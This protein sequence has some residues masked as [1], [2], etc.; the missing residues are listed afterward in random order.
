[1]V[2]ELE[3]GEEGRWEAFVRNRAEHA[4]YLRAGWR[5]VLEETYGH[6][7]RYLVAEEGGDVRGILPLLIVTSWWAGCYVTSLPGGICAAGEAAEDALLEA[8]VRLA[9]EADAD[10]LVLRD[11]RRPWSDDLMTSEAHCTLTLPLP[12][13]PE[14]LWDGFHP[15]VRNR[16]RKARKEGLSASLGGAE[17]VEPFYQVFSCNMRD[18]GTPVLSRD[19]VQNV[20]AAF[21]ERTRLVVVR[22]GE[23][24]VGGMLLLRAGGLVHNPW[25]SSRRDAFHLCPNDLLCWAALRWACERGCRTFD[26]GRSQ[27]GTGTFRF[28]AKWGAEPEPLYYQYYLRRGSGIPDP[29]LRA[30]ERAAYR[31]ARWAWQ[32]LP[33]ALTRLVGPPI[34]RVVNPLG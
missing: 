29:A 12:A 8:A 10:Y 6:G 5:Q 24:P 23:R 18:L 19:L 11:G 28:K 32:R 20:V 9:Q 2:R 4:V 30:E 1:M 25:I 7:T 22:Q 34:V 16:V 31:W 21:P 15:K 13:D 26:F 27:W 17:L 3:R 14:E 33:V